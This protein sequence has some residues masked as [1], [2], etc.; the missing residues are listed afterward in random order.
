MV[1]AFGCLGT[2]VLF[3]TRHDCQS[4][5]LRKGI[6]RASVF[7][8]KKGH[9][10]VPEF[11]S[12]QS[13]LLLCD[14]LASPV[15]LAFPSVTH[16]SMFG[17]KELLHH[18]YNGSKQHA[19]ALPQLNPQ[20][21][22]HLHCFGDGICFLGHLQRLA[23]AF[24]ARYWDTY[25]PRTFLNGPMNLSI[26]TLLDVR[27]ASLW[28]PPG[29]STLRT[30]RTTAVIPPNSHS[31]CAFAVKAPSRSTGG[32]SILSK[33]PIWNFP[34][35]GTDELVPAARNMPRS[36]ASGVEGAQQSKLLPYANKVTRETDVKQSKQDS[37][38]SRHTNPT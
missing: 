35:R 4:F 23:D 19:N 9:V 15:F 33:N 28:Q 36:S 29:A 32:A 30:G 22:H 3:F 1:I 38:S 2:L 17:F 8:P 18:A 16:Q 37:L 34:A 14:A 6:L 21:Q 31:T 5:H 24:C 20:F 7:A 26:Q 12:N 25:L 10:V 11:S 13:I 27:V